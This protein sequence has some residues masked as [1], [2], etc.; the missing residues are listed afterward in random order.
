MTDLPTSIGKITITGRHLLG[1]AD[2]IDTGT[3]PDSIV[4]IANVAI[5]N[6]APNPL[7][8]PSEKLLL[9]LD[10]I[11]A[12]LNSDGVLVA[13]ADGKGGEAS[14]TTN[15]TLVAPIQALIDFIDWEYTLE[16]SPITGTWTPFEVR[17]TGKPGDIID[18]SDAVISGR[19]NAA[20]RL[21]QGQPDV[22]IQEGTATT[23]LE[24]K[25]FMVDT[26]TNDFYYYAP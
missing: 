2:S 22:V 12:T 4:P 21:A 13:P 11:D 7:A 5:R 14:T 1:I 20:A 10:T 26:L 16:F 8:I 9:T 15:I 17:V 24:V 18:L 19:I 25:Q 6:N 3:T 23:D